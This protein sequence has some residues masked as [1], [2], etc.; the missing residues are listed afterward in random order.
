LI[1]QAS[2]KGAQTISPPSHRQRHPLG[3]HSF[4][5][6][7]NF[8]KKNSGTQN[9]DYQ[10]LLER[11]MEELK[12]KTSAHDNL[13]NLGTA[14][15]NADLD[16]RIIVFTSPNGIKATCS[17][18][19]IGTINTQ[20]SI[21]LWSW[22][23]ETIDSEL[24]LHAKAVK[25]Y[26]EENNIEQFTLRKFLCS[27]ETAWELVAIACKLGNAQGAYRG[28]AGSANVFMTYYNVQLERNDS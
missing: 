17:L 27:E 28:P 25:I 4:E 23:N 5:V 20:D 7:V 12:I 16:K 6:K 24:Q 19:I 9:K 3:C 26:G 2:Q 22:G 13:F 1:T 10:I 8:F 14:A 11:S 15:W 18:Q 21:W